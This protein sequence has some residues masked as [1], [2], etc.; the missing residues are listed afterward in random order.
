MST[1]K[2]DIEMIIEI[3]KIVVSFLTPLLV[4]IFGLLIS[5]QLEKRKSDVLKE[6]EWQTKWAELF[7]EQA[8]EFN[9]LTTNIVYLMNRLSHNEKRD[10]ELIEDLNKQLNESRHKFQYVDWHM[11]NFVQFAVKNKDN[12]LIKQK[13]LFSAIDKLLK[14]KK[15]NFYTNVN[16]VKTRQFE[17]NK[18]VRD[19]HNELL[20]HKTDNT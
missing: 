9:D 13:E 11:E 19:T 3:I 12:F 4:L 17:Y 10:I 2:E 7:L 15:E 18:L 16:D 20:T 1:N 6:K 5:K 14:G 8:N